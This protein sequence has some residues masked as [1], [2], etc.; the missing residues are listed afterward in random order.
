MARR[1]HDHIHSYAE[2]DVILHYLGIGATK[3]ELQSAME[4][5]EPR[6]LRHPTDLRGHSL[7]VGQHGPVA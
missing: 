4:I 7:L 6:S 2:C 3:E 1:V 5:L